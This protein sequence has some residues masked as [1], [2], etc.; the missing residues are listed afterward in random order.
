MQ[1][2]LNRCLNLKQGNIYSVETNF[3]SQV[4]SY[5][6]T[7]NISSVNNQKQSFFSLC[8]KWVCFFSMCFNVMEVS[9]TNVFICAF[10]RQ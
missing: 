5:A 2:H 7:K 10:H 9:Q 6:K 8:Y 4:V 1:N 3:K